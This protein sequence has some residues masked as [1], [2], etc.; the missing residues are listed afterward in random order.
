MVE[1]PQKRK[2]FVD[3]TLALIRK[4][5]FDGLDMDW[6]YPAA[7][8]GTPEDKVGAGY[9]EG[10]HGLRCFHWGNQSSLY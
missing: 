7:R 6:E 1:D 5:D 4:H 8:G 2:L 10:T 9:P 3:S